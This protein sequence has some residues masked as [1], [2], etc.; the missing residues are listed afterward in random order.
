M[1][2]L[3]QSTAVVP[4]F[5]ADTGS[6]FRRRDKTSGRHA[7]HE[8]R[9]RPGPGIWQQL[10]LSILIRSLSCAE[11]HSL[12]AAQVAREEGERGERE[13]RGTRQSR[14]EGPGIVLELLNCTGTGTR[15]RD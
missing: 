2:R 6:G 13:M 7:F 5:A 1:D 3:S 12:V 15:V 8:R 10:L 14:C 9:E 4:L 11:A